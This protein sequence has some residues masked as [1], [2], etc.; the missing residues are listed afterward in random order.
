[1]ADP[2]IRHRPVRDIDLYDHRAPWG[3][4][5]T[6]VAAAV[7]GCACGA[8]AETR[9]HESKDRAEARTLALRDVRSLFAAHLRHP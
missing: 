1:M 5:R 9:T 2:R 7:L 6:W 4:G 8:Y 3:Q